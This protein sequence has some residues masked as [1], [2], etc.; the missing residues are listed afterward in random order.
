MIL[1]NGLIKSNSDNNNDNDTTVQSDT[2]VHDEED[3]TDNEIEWNWD[4]DGKEL[5]ETEPVTVI[6]K[7]LGE[8]L[9]VPFVEKKID[10]PAT[11]IRPKIDDNIDD[12]DIKNKKMTKLEN[13][14]EDFFSDFDMTPTFKAA[15]NTIN[16]PQEVKTETESKSNRLQMSMVENL[17]NNDGWGDDENW[18]NDL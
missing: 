7:R 4:Q 3:L 15:T 6:E 5:S 1:S 14:A 13:Q 12:L 17:E 8:N 10:K 18:N 16:I 2:A 11:T 9:A